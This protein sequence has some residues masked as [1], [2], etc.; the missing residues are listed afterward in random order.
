[1]KFNTLT[2]PGVFVEV[3]NLGVLLTGKSGS[4]KSQLALE[5]ISRG[6]RLIADDAVVFTRHHTSEII[7]SCPPILQDFLAV[8]NLGVLNIRFLYGD[9]AVKSA[10][11]LI[12]IIEL[13]APHEHKPPHK[14]LQPIEKKEFILDCPFPH[15][16]FC[17]TN[18]GNHALLIE[19][20]IRNFDLQ[21]TSYNSVKSF[22][23]KQASFLLRDQIA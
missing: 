1:M 11:T 9:Q 8:P 17:L 23:E 3:F 7:G 5:L 14:A 10:Q 18:T 2:M 12:L 20:L 15:F 22:I 6:H 21:K 16:T 4:G 13:H 19:L